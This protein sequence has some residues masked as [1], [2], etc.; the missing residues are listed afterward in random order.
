LRALYYAR[1]GV[2]YFQLW[3]FPAAI[4]GDDSYLAVSVHAIAAGHGRDTFAS[5]RIAGSGARLAAFATGRNA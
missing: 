1:F 4:A 3:A 2:M 5:T